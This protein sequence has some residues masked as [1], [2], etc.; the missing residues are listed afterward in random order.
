M[1]TAET[2]VQRA[3]RW[4]RLLAGILLFPALWLGLALALDAVVPLARLGVLALAFGL[5]PTAALAGLVI[6]L[7]ARRA[8]T[9]PLAVLMSLALV[10]YGAGGLAFLASVPLVSHRPAETARIQPAPAPRPAETAESPAQPSPP[11]APV[12]AGPP[13]TKG[14]PAAGGA[15]GG[16]SDG[17]SRG[18][19][20]IPQFPWPPPAASAT[21]VL[22]ATALAG[23]ATVGQVVTSIVS[24]LEGKGYVERSFFST[25]ADGVALVTRLERINEDGSSA[26]DRERWPAQDASRSSANLAQLL[27]GLFYVDPGRYRVIAFI[28]Q[29]AP[30]AQ[31]A[32]QITGDQARSWLRSGANVLPRELAERSFAGHCTALVYEFASDG[33]AVR[34]VESRLT[35]RQHLE[36]AGVLAVLGRAN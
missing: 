19:E 31:S 16:G 18:R 35:G 6:W 5:A 13:A 1:A 20:P 7:I 29:D 17:G 28:I 33:A 21:Y 15:P 36:K 32:E 9:R 14:G 34:V 26:A 24:A 30:F 11:A 25:P 12:R 27:R 8:R 4:L 23:A 22:P 3:P 10:G 2:T